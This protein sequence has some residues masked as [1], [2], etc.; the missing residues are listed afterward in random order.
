M[1]T[2][3]LWFSL[4]ER[5]EY[6]GDVPTIYPKGFFEWE[7]IFEG[8]YDVIWKEL[9]QYMKQQQPESYFNYEMVTKPQ[10][11]KTI[12]LMSWG[13]KFHKHLR[14]FPETY[15]LL[16]QIP[17]LVSIS[18][19]VLEPESDIVEHFGDTNG[20]VRCHYGLKVP[21]ELPAIGFRVKEDAQSWR[22]GELLIFCDGYVHTA[23]NHTKGQRIILLF[24]VILPEFMPKK[25]LICGTVLTSIFFQSILCRLKL[26]EPK[27][28][29]FKKA[30]YHTAKIF[31][32]LLTP[33]YNAF[34]KLKHGGLN[35]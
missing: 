16:K 30:L 17:G 14:N 31:A 18:F 19:N 21:G 29:L 34:G 35:H 32:I 26:K 8:K 33:V 27:N 12:P 24:D 1:K 22:E 6:P 4:F 9:E 5:H 10:A 23:F 20:M 3:K 7:R 2:P 15:A 28:E 25:K 13:V 11:W